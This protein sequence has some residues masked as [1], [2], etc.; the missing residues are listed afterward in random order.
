MSLCPRASTSSV[1]P[2]GTMH[3]LTPYCIRPQRQP[4]DGVLHSTP[5]PDS[6]TEW[7]G[8]EVQ[9]LMQGSETTSGAGAMTRSEACCAS[10]KILKMGEA[11]ALASP[12]LTYKAPELCAGCEK[13][14][15]ALQVH[16]QP[17]EPNS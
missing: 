11:V 10:M 17:A 15:Q 1:G 16:G 4:E 14:R 3:L 7:K 6:E 12:V 13:G 8:G 9:E 5:V 2:S